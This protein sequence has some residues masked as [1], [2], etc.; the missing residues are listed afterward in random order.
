MTSLVDT[1]HRAGW[2]GRLLWIALALSL[3]LNLCVFA[4]IAWMHTHAPP[5]PMLRMQHFGQ[6]LNLN[7]DQRRAF[8]QFLRTIRLRGRFVRESNQPLIDDIWSEIAKPAP[9]SST[10]AKLAD[11]VNGNRESFQ[12][13]V[14]AAL[15]AFIKTL[16][17]D[18][19]AQ[20]AAKAKAPGDEA[21]RRLFQM[22]VP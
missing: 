7:D 16:N 15:D 20:F 8:E 4:G 14:S 3:T 6:T 12:R 1:G 17:P 5:G 9:D 10:V 2:R 19:R 22:V 21:A 18:Q 13:D 11:Q